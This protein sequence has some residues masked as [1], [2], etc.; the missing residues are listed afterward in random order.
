MS[1]TLI[2][3][4]IFFKT[5]KINLNNDKW[6]LNLSFSKAENVSI[7]ELFSF[8]KISR[9]IKEFF[10]WLNRSIKFSTLYSKDMPGEPLV[11][12]NNNFNI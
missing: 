6:I 2:P 10:N 1:F 3:N 9:S 8:E 11:I 12:S 5:T 4:F 7:K